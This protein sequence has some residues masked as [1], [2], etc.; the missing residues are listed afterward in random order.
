MWLETNDT[1]PETMPQI[2]GLKPHHAKSPSSALRPPL[3]NDNPP[4]SVTGLLRE[5]I[6]TFNDFEALATESCFDFD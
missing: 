3:G 4:K 1:Q 5:A 6:V 2:N